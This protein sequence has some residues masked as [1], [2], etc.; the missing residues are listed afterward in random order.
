MIFMA[1]FGVAG[2]IATMILMIV[3]SRAKVVG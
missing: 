1:A 3:V 2:M